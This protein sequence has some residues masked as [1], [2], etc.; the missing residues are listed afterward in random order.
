MTAVLKIEDLHV[1][2]GEKPILR[3]VDLIINHGEVIFEPED[4]PAGLENIIGC[5]FRMP[6]LCAAVGRAQLD[7]LDTVNDWRTRNADILREELTG[8]PGIVL[9]PSQRHGD[10]GKS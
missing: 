10:H 4:D 3:G 2:V 5:N 8:L 6:E 7:K 1:N 9:P